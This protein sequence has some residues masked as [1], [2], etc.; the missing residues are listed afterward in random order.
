MEYTINKA[1][2]NTIILCSSL[3]ILYVLSSRLFFFFYQGAPIEALPIFIQNILYII[4]YGYITWTFFDYFRHYKLTVLQTSILIIFLME[5]VFKSH[6]LT[7]ILDSTLEQTL[8]LIT[9]AVWIIAS[10]ILIVFLFK[11]KGRAYPGIGSIRKYAVSMILL[12]I[13]VTTIP[14][15]VKQG[16][17]FSTQQLIGLAFVIPY[18]FTMEF[19]IKS[20][21]RNKATK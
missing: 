20:G 11:L 12:F 8:F 21:P 6:L 3:L 14:F 1:K 10:V 13:L 19:A 2:R 18:I 4:L 16:Q 9:N 15:W 5:V 7:N 17:A